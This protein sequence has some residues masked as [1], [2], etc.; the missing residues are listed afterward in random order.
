[1]VYPVVPTLFAR[2]CTRHFRQ[3]LVSRVTG[4]V[5]LGQFHFSD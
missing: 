1:M 3:I 5:D 2:K 4:H